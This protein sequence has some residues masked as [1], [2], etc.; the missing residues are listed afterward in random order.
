[1]PRAQSAKFSR[2]SETMT[3]TSPDT[4]RTT[5]SEETIAKASHG[6]EDPSNVF[7]ELSKAAMDLRK[8]DMHASNEEASLGKAEETAAKCCMIA[9]IGLICLL[10]VTIGVLIIAP[11]RAFY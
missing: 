5:K 10:I 4:P 8:A 6:V 2:S 9:I 3:M 1:M 7:M 11:R